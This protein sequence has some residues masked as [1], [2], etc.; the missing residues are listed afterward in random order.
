MHSRR[1]GVEIVSAGKPPGKRVENEN[2]FAD[3]LKVV[4][5]IREMELKVWSR[6]VE[7]NWRAPSRRTA[8]FF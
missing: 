6:I 8:T 1:P 3:F 5:F 7:L 4:L 2:E